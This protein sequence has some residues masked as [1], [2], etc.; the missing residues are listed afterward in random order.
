MLVRHRQFILLPQA[1]GVLAELL[2]QGQQLV[3]EAQ[4]RLLLVG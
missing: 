4:V 2:V 3:V 1:A